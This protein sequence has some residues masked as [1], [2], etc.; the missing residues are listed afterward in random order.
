MIEL[1]YYLRK[2]RKAHVSRIHAEVYVKFKVG[3]NNLEFG[4]AV[5]SI[6]L[7]MGTSDVLINTCPPPK[8]GNR[9]APRRPYSELPLLYPVSLFQRPLTSSLVADS[10][11]LLFQELI[12]KVNVLPF[13]LASARAYFLSIISIFL[14]NLFSPA[15]VGPRRHSSGCP[16]RWRQTQGACPDSVVDE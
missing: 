13:T 12:L 9:S 4:H 8:K 3:K 11:L 15:C 2:N 1:G 7:K 16:G 5:V 10:C 6:H 14:P